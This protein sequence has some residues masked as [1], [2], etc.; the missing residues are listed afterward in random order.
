MRNGRWC[1]R[2]CGK[3]VIYFPRYQWDKKGFECQACKK[4]YSSKEMG[5][6]KQTPNLF[7]KPKTLKLL[8]EVR[9]YH[10]KP[11]IVFD[12]AV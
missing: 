7:L 4:R 10:R 1:F 2:G 3:K 9:R 11:K 6:K 12:Y 8:K 5:V